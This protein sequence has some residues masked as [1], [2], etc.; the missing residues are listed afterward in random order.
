MTVTLLPAVDIKG[1]KAVRLLK[2][3]ADK[4]TIYGE[5]VA[6]AQK[7]RAEG[8]QWLHVVDLDAAFGSGSNLDV[9]TGIVTTVSDGLHVEVSGGIRTTEALENALNT[10][11]ARVSV[12][13]AALENPAWMEDMLGRWADRIAIDLAAVN[14]N[15]EW[16]VRGNGWVSDGGDLWEVLERFDAAG[17]R[18]FVVTDVSR[19]GALT[20]PNVELLREVAEAT[21]AKIT[22]SGGVS[23][24]DDLVG[25]AAYEEEGID[26]IIIGKALYSGQFTLPEALAA[27]A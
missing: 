22:A 10:G 8:A 9:V 21:E 18:R 5:P 11:A 16:G 3:E 1:G 14:E 13:T 12:G 25:L 15:G 4:E 17:A 24:L 27:V 26:A 2:G 19:D 23:S 7:F 20:G 6:A